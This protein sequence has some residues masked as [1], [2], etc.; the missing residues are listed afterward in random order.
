MKNEKNEILKEFKE[1]KITFK[2]TYKY[3]PNKE[4]EWNTKYS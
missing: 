3:E 4:E 2:P 1:A